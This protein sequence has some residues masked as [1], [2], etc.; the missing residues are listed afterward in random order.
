MAV[1]MQAVQVINVA[2]SNLLSYMAVTKFLHLPV[3]TST[4]FGF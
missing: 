4:Y 2:F 3:V 1:L